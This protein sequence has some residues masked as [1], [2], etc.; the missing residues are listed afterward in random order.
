MNIVDEFIE[1]KFE[2]PDNF[3]KIKETLSRIGIASRKDKILYQSCHILHKAGKYY[4][5]HFKELFML[6]GKETT[7]VKDDLDRRDTIIKLLAEWNLLT[8][9]EP[10]RLSEKNSMSTIKIISH[11][12]KPEW[13]IVQKYDIGNK[14][15]PIKGE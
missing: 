2:N 11:S 8:V 12:E 4:I 15:Y 3:L 5:V 1:V 7:L 14:R 10:T 9:V 13:S 6:D